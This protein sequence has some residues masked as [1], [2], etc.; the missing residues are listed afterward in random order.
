MRVAGARIE[1]SSG[2]SDSAP[3]IRRV[4]R[5]GR[6]TALLAIA[7]ACA[8]PAGALPA[9]AAAAARPGQVSGTLPLARGAQGEVRLID[10]SSRTVSLAR[11]VRGSG[12][13]TLSA[14]AGGY[15]LVGAAVP[16]RGRTL[17]QATLP[18][19]LKSG[20]RRKKLTLRRKK[21][22]RAKRSGARAASVQELGQ[23][24]PGRIAVEI[25]AFTGATGELA[26]L[27]R[28]MAAMLI[29]DVV[30]A[31]DECGIDVLEVEHRDA[32]LKELELQ[33]SPY[34]DQSTTVRRNFVLGD[35]EIKGTL[36][37]E[38]TKLGYDVR[39]VDKRTGNELGRIEGAMNANDAFAGEQQLARQLNEELCKLSDV[40]EVTL[41]VT[42][43]ATFA[44]HLAGGAVDSTIRAL[45]PNRRARTWTGDGQYAWSGL[46][47]VSKLPECSYVSP[48]APVAP[49]NVKLADAGSAQ[50]Q[51]DWAPG[52]SDATTAT[53]VCKDGSVPGQPG[54][55]LLTTGP[56][57]FRVPYAGGSQAVTG[58]L[59]SGGDGWE[60]TGTI[61]VKPAGV[62]RAAP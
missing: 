20:Q 44:T 14:P 52:S 27:N 55:A 54:T 34:F 29:T 53:I 22:V 36:S 23:V 1:G 12:R 38:G 4:T 39:L 59:V 35:V 25:P 45:R 42:G 33:K 58:L 43:S 18:V 26:V 46:T 10:A 24:T 11:T 32:I 56:N 47:F 31:G 50:L 15:L 8:A 51:V 19:S 16:R 13:F 49:W 28:G 17:T 37:T 40:Y 5:T 60:N 30:Q 41:K 61:T 3:T 62:A 57:S 9:G 6:M 48:V 2:R 7:I 21:K